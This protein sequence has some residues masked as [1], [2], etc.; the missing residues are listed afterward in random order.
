MEISNLIN[1]H[2]SINYHLV[3]ISKELDI[4]QFIKSVLITIPWI[5]SAILELQWVKNNLIKT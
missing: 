4:A 5:L 1:I 2:Q 3:V